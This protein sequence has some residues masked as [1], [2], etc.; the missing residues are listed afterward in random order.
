MQNPA[1]HVLNHSINFFPKYHSLT[2]LTYFLAHVLEDIFMVC[3]TP[4]SKICVMMMQ[5]TGVLNHLQKESGCIRFL[6]GTSS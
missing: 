4:P 5:L 3:L 2:Y 6:E 1:M